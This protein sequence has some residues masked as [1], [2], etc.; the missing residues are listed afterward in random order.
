[1]IEDKRIGDRDVK[2]KR[3]EKLYIADWIGKSDTYAT[4]HDNALVYTKEELCR[5]KEVYELV[6]NSGYP[7]PN[8]ALHLLMDGNI[9]GLLALTAADLERAFKVYGIHP[10]YVR[11]Q[12]TK[13]KVSRAQV[14]LGLRSTDKNLRMFADVMHLE[15]NMF[16]VTVAD[17]LILTMQCYLENESRMALGMALQEQLALLK[18]RGLC[19]KTLDLQVVTL[20]W[21]SKRAK[22]QIFYLLIMLEPARI[23]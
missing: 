6:K 11:G 16:L 10:E 8:E 13:K 20:Y 9:W 23:N 21:E 18:S 22:Q 5:A 7:S 2:F 15:G 4:V 12:L 3:R 17:P 14:D 19:D 1:M